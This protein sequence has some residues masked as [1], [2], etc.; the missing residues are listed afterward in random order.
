MVA[1]NPDSYFALPELGF[2]L[3]P[4]AGGTVSLPRRLG[5]QRGA[6]LILT[7]SR[8]DAHPA[9]DWGHTDRTE[10]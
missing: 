3:V 2:G 6:Y 4:G 9:L 1:R 10:E 5:R 8:I 7:G